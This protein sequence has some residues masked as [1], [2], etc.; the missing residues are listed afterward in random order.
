MPKSRVLWGPHIVT[1]AIHTMYFLKKMDEHRPLQ[2]LPSNQRRKRELHRPSCE[3]VVRTIAGTLTAGVQ[4]DSLL[5]VE[6]GVLGGGRWARPSCHVSVF[7][8]EFRN[9]PL[10]R[11]YI[12]LIYGRYLQ[13]RFLEFPLSFSWIVQTWACF[14]PCNKDE[15]QWDFK[16][17]ELTFWWHLSCG[18]NNRHCRYHHP[19]QY[20]TSKLPEF[21]SRGQQVV[22][23]SL[24]QFWEHLSSHH[25]LPWPLPRVINVVG[26]E[27][28]LR[29]T[30][31]L[32]SCLIQ[33]GTEL[34]KSPPVIWTWQRKIIEKI[35]H[36]ERLR[37]YITYLPFCT[38]YS[39]LAKFN[40]RRATP[41]SLSSAPE[42]P[43][44][45]VRPCHQCPFQWRVGG[46]GHCCP[47][48]TSWQWMSR[49][50]LHHGYPFKYIEFFAHVLAEYWIQKKAK[51]KEWVHVLLSFS[52]S[53]CEQLFM[54]FH[55]GSKIWASQVT[56]AF[57][58]D[59]SSTI[60]DDMGYS[61]V[62]PIL[63]NLHMHLRTDLWMHPEHH[64]L[65]RSNNCD[66]PRR[67]NTGCH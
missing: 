64:W 50:R 22:N 5:D 65:G 67:Q 12:G 41:S 13:F 49:Q 23:P 25:R 37:L 54:W 20:F 29:R 10:H 1:V 57:K 61:H 43:R 51:E 42:R 48:V 44:H 59:W 40:Q 53:V 66:P 36:L 35:A 15:K 14:Y 55:M 31:L 7:Q 58:T 32:T 52:P 6:N 38:W 62:L 24:G 56:M 8:W 9:I 30:Q 16:G 60:L 11:H 39:Y 18:Q 34:R 46:L 21:A 26:D 33:M 45:T 17:T 47:P 28:H 3:V 4:L 63:G 19:Y 27:T 2:A